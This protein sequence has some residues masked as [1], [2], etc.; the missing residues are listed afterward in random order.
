MHKRTITYVD[1]D[2]NTR[3]EEHHFHLN[4]SELAKMELSVKGGFTS[5][6][7]RIINAQD[8]P[9]LLA[10]FED[11]VTKSYGIKTPDG[12]GF[13]KKTEYLEDFMSTEAY[14]QLFMELITDTNAFVAFV[15]EIIPADMNQKPAA[16]TPIPAP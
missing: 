12:R 8:Q 10:A 13:V 15:N 5:Y 1:Y 2:G 9:A 4:K 3:T 6:I 7:Q 14:S 16:V 11:I